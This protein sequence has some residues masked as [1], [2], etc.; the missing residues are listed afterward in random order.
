M[1]D[2]IPL[3]QMAEA[4]LTTADA[5]EKT[6]LSRRFAALW[7]AARAAG[8]RPEIGTASP[9]DRP[10]R[11]DAPALLDPRDVPRRRPGTPEDAR[12]SCTRSP[13]SS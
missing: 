3:A 12:P 8:E 5:R 11:P 1:T 2:M 9:P 6:A 7:Q 13:I 4:V 10:A